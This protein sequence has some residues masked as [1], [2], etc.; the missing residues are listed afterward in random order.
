MILSEQEN[1][2]CFKLLTKRGFPSF[3]R[4]LSMLIFSEGVKISRE[5]VEHHVQGN[6]LSR[7]KIIL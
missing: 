7:S 2:N 1:D 3:P 6:L 5:L 4:F